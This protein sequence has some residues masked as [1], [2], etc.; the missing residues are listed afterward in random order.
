MRSNDLAHVHSDKLFEQVYD[1]ILERIRRGEWKA[2]EKLPS[3]RT[4]A[5]ELH[6]HRLT[7]F[8]AYQMLK[9]NRAVYVKDKSGYY[10][11]PGGSLPVETQHDPIVSA[12]VQES[13][14]SEIHQVQ[15]VYQFS[16]ALLD[17][18]L[19]PNH[20]FSEYVKKVFDMYPKVLGTYSTVQGDLELREALCRYFTDH[21]RFYLSADELLITSGAQEAIDLIARVL[22][23]AR[24]VVL[25]ERPTYAPAIDVFRRQGARMIPVEIDRD[26]Y[27]LDWVERLMQTYKPR[28]F[29]LNPTFHN[30]TGYTVPAEQRKRL[31]ELAHQYQCLLIEDDPC[32][33]IYFEQKPP[34]PFFAYD[35][36]GYVIYIRSFSKY[37]APGLSI[38]MVACRPSVMKYVVKAKALSDSG[39]PLLNQKIFLHYFFSERMQQHLAKLRTALAIRKEIMEDELSAAGWQWSSPTGGFNLWIRLPESVPVDTLLSKSMEQSVSFVPGSICDPLRSYQSWIRLSYSYLNEQ[40]LREGLKRFVSLYRSLK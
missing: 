13:G 20:Y 27:P 4:L 16:K 31:V 17:P 37:I 6:V 14:L 2:H 25:L 5:A 8:K 15:A 26:G 11:Q 40:Q 12:F 33:D 32:P 1:Y 22:V 29:Y 23:K 28:L 18:N 21:Y 9:G 24:D 19:L 39:A 10:V 36:A 34:L 3:I 30:P 7:V 38:A 35:T